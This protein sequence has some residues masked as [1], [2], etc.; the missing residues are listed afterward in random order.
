MASI[1]VRVPCGPRAEIPRWYLDRPA[2]SSADMATCTR[3]SNNTMVRVQVS[4]GYRAN[5]HFAP[6][7]RL[8]VWVPVEHFYWVL[9]QTGR[10]PYIWAYGAD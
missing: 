3:V 6:W 1:F 4:S 10:A 9:V 8:S 5:D 2:G 7:L